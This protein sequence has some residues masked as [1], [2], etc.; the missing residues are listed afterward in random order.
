MWDIIFAEDPSL[1]LVDFV[2]LTMILRL[3]WDRE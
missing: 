2:C 1:E 3:H